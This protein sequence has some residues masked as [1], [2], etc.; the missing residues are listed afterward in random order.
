MW[1]AISAASRSVSDESAAVAL[2]LWGG[3]VTL[4]VLTGA[5]GSGKT[6]LAHAAEVRLG[7]KIDVRYFDSVGV[8]STCQMIAEH[9][10]GEGWQRATTVQ[11]M[12]RIGA[13]VQSGRKVLFEGQTRFSFLY[14]AVAAAKV[15]D[16]R[17]ILVDC[18]D[19]T[20]TRRLVAERRQPELAN[21]T[22]M[23]WARFL[24]DEAERGGHEVLDTSAKSLDM[25]VDLICRHF[26]DL[27]TPK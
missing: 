4:V 26:E 1:S 7:G 23:N 15:V 14:E 16:Y 8:P 2:D 21:P 3:R 24:R 22:M 27:S 17:L 19:A 9:G 5:S 6:T 25:C 20:R 11:W 18:D 10:S 13:L 12:H